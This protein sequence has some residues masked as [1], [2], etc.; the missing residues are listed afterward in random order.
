MNHLN[1]RDV[2]GY[3]YQSLA[4]ARREEIDRHLAACPPCRARL[5][6]QE[7][8]QQ[9]IH[10]SLVADLKT[11]RPSP[12]MGFAAIAPRLKRSSRLALVWNQSLRLVSG[13]VVLTM[14]VALAV[15]LI[16]LFEGANRPFESA[17][18]GA[19]LRPTSASQVREMT[20]SP[21]EHPVEA[22]F[23]EEAR[24]VGY[25]LST[26]QPKPG[27]VLTVTLYWQA[28]RKMTK[29]YA[30]SIDLLD[31][32]S[33]SVASHY[34]G[35]ADGARPTSS[36]V[37]GEYIADSQPL[38]LP[39]NLALSPSGYRLA[40]RLY[41][42]DTHA[43][44][45]DQVVLD[46]SI[47]IA[48]RAEYPT[49]AEFGDQVRLVGYDLSAAQLTPGSILTV[50]LY[51][52]AQRK[53]DSDYAVFVHLFDASG[54]LVT[55]HDGGLAEG[56]RPTMGWLPGEYVADP[57]RLTIPNELAPGDYRL[58]LG[59]YD[60][61]TQIRLGDSVSLDQPVSVTAFLTSTA[62]VTGTTMRLPWAFGTRH[63]VI[64]D[65]SEATR[66]ELGFDLTSET[67]LAVDDGTVIYAEFD[68]TGG[69][70]MIKIQHSG[71]SISVYSHLSRAEVKNNDRVQRGQPIG[72]SGSS[73]AVTGPFLGF[74]VLGD[75]QVPRIFEE[76]GRELKKGD[77][78]ISQNQR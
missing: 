36:W 65:G 27:T 35:L 32:Y 18:P 76:V 60:A 17:G 24:L 61:K 37:P 49:H 50:T 56:T 5:A 13:A 19:P 39:G 64:Q 29:D 23:G 1:D 40:V 78:V 67:V 31:A 15:V 30:V 43:L 21:A 6:D 69:G 47:S 77:C 72:I 10:H 44:L 53:M 54:Q 63:C 70:Y 8:F 22:R 71:G 75:S 7:A 9:H 73:G 55:V 34:A 59:L 16:A 51:W 74:T 66:H 28:Q 25:D 26:T 52:Q 58:E 41:D 14:L 11:F 68:Q 57:H 20:P 12:Q 3:I 45:G 4:D 33:V 2:A 46:Q 42:P 48:P 38:A 62:N